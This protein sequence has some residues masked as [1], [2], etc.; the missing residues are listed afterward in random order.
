MQT[1][2]TA[3]FVASHVRQ[4]VCLDLSVHILRVYMLISI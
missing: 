4:I 2:Q 1:D 3:Q